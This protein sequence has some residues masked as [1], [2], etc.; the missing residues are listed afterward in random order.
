MRK[1]SVVLMSL[2]AL[3]VS[4]QNKIDFAGRTLPDDTT[5]TYGAI[6]E[7]DSKDA[8]F[9][10]CD[11]D[12]VS[13]LGSMA[14]VNVTVKQ[15]EELA[16]LPQVVHISVGQENKPMEEVNAEPTAIELVRTCVDSLDFAPVPTPNNERLTKVVLNLCRRYKARTAK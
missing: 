4:A 11:V 10:D 6:V 12:V 2:I 9:G 3:G 8:A 16:A 14:V 15:M 1:L 7:L 13:R 5:L